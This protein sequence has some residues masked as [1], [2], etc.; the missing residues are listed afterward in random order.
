MPWLYWLIAVITP[1][2][3]K[4][5][6]CEWWKYYAS[7]IL[8]FRNQN[9]TVT[10][11]RPRNLIQISPRLF[12]IM[13]NSVGAKEAKYTSFFLKIPEH[14]CAP[15]PYPF[16][17]CGVSK[18]VKFSPRRS[19]MTIT[20]TILYNCYPRFILHG[21]NFSQI[22]CHKWESWFKVK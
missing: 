20:L 6:N 17:V 7:K 18:N 14:P 8:L 11:P 19:K 2:D 22:F 12:I 21:S 16:L 13:T 1:W 3:L 9:H 4:H 5:Y 10:G 15:L